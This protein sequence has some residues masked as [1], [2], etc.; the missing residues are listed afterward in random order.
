M[1]GRKATARLAARIDVSRAGLVRS[2]RQIARRMTG[3]G[4]AYLHA[5]RKRLPMQSVIAE[6]VEIASC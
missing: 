6:F 1:R 2:Q 5:E 4:Y 3:N